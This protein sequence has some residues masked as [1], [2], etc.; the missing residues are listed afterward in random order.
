MLLKGCHSDDI[1]HRVVVAA[2]G[3]E[4]LTRLWPKAWRI[5]PDLRCSDITDHTSCFKVVTVA[6]ALQTLSHR[7]VA[8]AMTLQTSLCASIELLQQ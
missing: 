5:Y 1:R 3:G 6:M 8:I 2:L 7:V 4:H